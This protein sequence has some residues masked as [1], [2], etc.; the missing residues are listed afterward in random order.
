MINTKSKDFFSIT[1]K[2]ITKTQ[3]KVCRFCKI[4][5]VITDFHKSGS[6]PG[7]KGKRNPVYDDGYRS[8]CA[9]CRSRTGPAHSGAAGE[10]MKRQGLIRPPIGTPCEI[11]GRTNTKLFCDHDHKTGV[12]RGWLC[13][14]CNSALAKFGDNEEGVMRL[15]RYL[16]K[17]NTDK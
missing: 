3:T 9:K 6:K 7:W 14:G 4:E 5:K 10:L 15:V 8:E 2:D 17:T 1:E 12:F 13:N 16:Q 11:C